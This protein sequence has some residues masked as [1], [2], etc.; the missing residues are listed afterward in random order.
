MRRF[1]S[2]W[3]ALV[4]MMIVGTAARADE[5]SRRQITTSGQAVLH[6]APDEAVVAVGVET[7]HLTLAQAKRDNKSLSRRLLAAVEALGVKEADIQT[8]GL[9]VHMEYKV[10]DEPA[11]GIDG[12]HVRHAYSI[13]L[14]DVGRLEAL[15][16]A[17]LTHGANRLGGIEFRSSKL[18][19]HRDEARGLAVRAAKEKAQALAKELG[20]TVGAPVTID[21]A[22]SE[23]W[24][25][26]V[27]RSNVA[28]SLEAPDAG[29]AGTLR[30]GRIAVRAGVKVAFDL[31]P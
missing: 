7:F 22:D 25:G 9:S 31:I 1:W 26:Y 5:A 30:G 21:E 17:V 2:S 4:V 20:A 28:R 12:Y 3:V 6:V 19:A 10:R 27:N 18:R 29:G 23:D 11:K 24:W 13:V 16:D 14:R 15:V 8:E